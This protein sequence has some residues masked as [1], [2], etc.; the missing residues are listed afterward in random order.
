MVR[1][2]TNLTATQIKQAKPK[3]KEYTLADGNGLLLR[4]LYEQKF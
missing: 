1:L 2:T 4:I 3:E